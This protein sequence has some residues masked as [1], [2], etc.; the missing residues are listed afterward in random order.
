LN[1]KNLLKQEE[2]YKQNISRGFTRN[3]LVQERP[4]RRRGSK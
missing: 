2:K 1:N 3:R 4:S